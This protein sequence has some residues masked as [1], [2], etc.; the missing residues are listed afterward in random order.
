MSDRST[1]HEFREAL[2]PLLRRLGRQRTLSL[3]KVGV[4][5]HLA[6]HG[7]ATS[8]ELAT[9]QQISPQA[10][11]IAVR[12]LETLGLVERSPDDQDRRRVWIRLTD[13]GRER[14]DEE[15]AAGQAWL[16][17]A[18]VER[19]SADE[20]ET[21]ESVIPILRKLGDTD[22]GRHPDTGSRR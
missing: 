15:H 17:T 19:L 21:L 2:R 1:A 4:L 8:S 14:L 13:S 9:A 6:D 7:P 20:R 10:I 16:D 3:G 12:E 5:G 18:I 11:T 22:G